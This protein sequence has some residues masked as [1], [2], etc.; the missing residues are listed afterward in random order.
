MEMEAILEKLILILVGALV[1]FGTARV[2]W[3][4][5]KEK[6][7]MEERRSRIRS[8]REFIHGDFEQLSCHETVAY[9]EMRPHLSPETSGSIEGGAIILRQGRGGN[10]IKSL[11]LD[12]L[13]RLEKEWK[14]I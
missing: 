5:E 9:S 6:L 7:L 3:S 14:L 4:I 10:V 1:G 13:A 11:V 12:D 8:W 2:K